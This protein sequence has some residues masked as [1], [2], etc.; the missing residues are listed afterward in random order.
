[1]PWRLRTRGTSIEL[2]PGEFVIGRGASCHL[3]IDDATVS[4]RHAILH[5]SSKGVSLEDLGS[6]NGVL[7]NGVLLRGGAVLKD[8]DVLVIGGCELRLSY[9]D[10]Q[11]SV[12]RPDMEPFR[13]VVIKD[14]ASEESA[15]GPEQI[16]TASSSLLLDLVDKALGSGK[17]SDADWILGKLATEMDER[18][19][20]GQ[21]ITAD[22]LEQTA[23]RAMRTAS[24][25]GDARWLDWVFDVYGKSGVVL[26]AALI[27][28]LHPIVRKLR[29]ATSRSLAEYV[30]TLR[31]GAAQRSAAERFRLQRIEGLL[32]VAKS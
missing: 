2:P 31:A 1:M 21:P 30:Q 5:T 3:L 26:S 24:A 20:A 25:L 28:E 29:M 27:D 6:R 19:A 17:P 11:M 15:L 22:S 13:G 16:P 23:R 9:D 14:G 4:R 8:D 18:A 10:T 32:A 12:T 7:L